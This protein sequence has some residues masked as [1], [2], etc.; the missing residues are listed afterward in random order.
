MEDNDGSKDVT[1]ICDKV[2][3]AVSSGCGDHE[4]PF[5][6]DIS[7][8]LQ[9]SLSSCIPAI[10]LPSQLQHLSPDLPILYVSCAKPLMMC[11]FSR[12]VGSQTLTETPHPQAP[13]DDSK[14]DRP[15]TQL[16]A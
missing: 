3:E 1:L 5:P 10:Q 4:T 15:C 11:V 14:N 16:S 12:A 9:L 2:I 8:A 7:L 6:T 13:E